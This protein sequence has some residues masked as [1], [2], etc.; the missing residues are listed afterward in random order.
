MNFRRVA[1]KVEVVKS[2][3]CFWCMALVAK[4]TNTPMHPLMKQGL[5]TGPF[6]TKTGPV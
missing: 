3:M 4:H 2:D 6:L 5:R 1:I